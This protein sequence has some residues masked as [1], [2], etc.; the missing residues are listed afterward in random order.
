MA[1]TLGEVAGSPRGKGHPRLLI[2]GPLLGINPGYITTIGDQ[3]LEMFREAGYPTVGASHSTN[4]YLRLLDIASTI[5]RLRSGVDILSIVVYGGPS[6][7][8]EDVASALG[9]ACG[10]PIVMSLHGGAMPQF[11]ARFPRWTRRVLR[12]ADALVVPSSYLATA[13]EGHGLNAEVIPN[14]IHLEEYPFRRRVTVQPRLLWMRAFHSIYH[15][16]MAIRVLARV[17]KSRPGAT[18]VMAGQDLGLRHGVEQ[19]AAELGLVDSVRFA[20]FLDPEGKR[21]EFA[22]ADIF[23][24]TNRIDNQPVSVLEACATGLPVVA[25]SVGGIPF[26]LKHEETGLLVDDG[27]VDAMAKA[28][29]RLSEDGAL[30]ARLSVNGRT[31]AARSDVRAVIRL[32]E[33]LFEGL[34]K[35]R[36]TPAEGGAL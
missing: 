6:F 22:Q 29:V 1:A 18:L 7:V 14:I 21:H 32:W 28:I 36:T 15:P 33:C 11:M 24:N 8:V 4:R 16:E 31:L 19:L 20:G 23:I 26:L 5:G 9:R 27:D 3:Y 13:L 2:V 35:N 30:A 10:L 25:T 34:L 17:R 12:R